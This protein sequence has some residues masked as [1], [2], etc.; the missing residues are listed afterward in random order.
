MQPV[1]PAKRTSWH[2]ARSEERTE[3]PAGWDRDNEEAAR[4]KNGEVM[5][6]SPPHVPYRQERVHGVKKAA[7]GS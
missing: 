1:T 7:R 2:E 3:R 5:A 6:T 4:Q